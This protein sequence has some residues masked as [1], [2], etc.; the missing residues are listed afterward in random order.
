MNQWPRY[1]GTSKRTFELIFPITFSSLFSI[2]SSQYDGYDLPLAI[3]ALSNSKVN[4]QYKSGGGTGIE[5][6]VIGI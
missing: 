5:C 1:K 6:M 4:Y 2:V 3:Y